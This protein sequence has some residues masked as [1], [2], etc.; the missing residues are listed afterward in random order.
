MK[1]TYLLYFI[2]QIPFIVY[3]YQVVGASI[4]NESL[5]N[6]MESGNVIE[7]GADINPIWKS[8]NFTDIRNVDNNKIQYE[9][10][11]MRYS[12]IGSFSFD[13][14]LENL[15]FNSNVFVLQIYVNFLNEAIFAEIFPNTEK[16]P[17]EIDKAPNGIPIN[18]KSINT[19]CV[20]SA[21]SIATNMALGAINKISSLNPPFKKCDEDSESAIYSINLFLTNRDTMDYNFKA[22]QAKFT[23]NQDI[24]G[25]SP[26]YSGNLLIN[27]DNENEKNSF[28]FSVNDMVTEC[29]SIKIL[30]E[31]SIDKYFNN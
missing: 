1:I 11:S 8:C 2:I 23:I 14:S 20:Y 31:F 4:T 13:K 7:Q 5:I 29:K 25:L 12:L 27:S 10:N 22:Q 18:I 24:S 16:I 6:S 3:N 19:D 26:K 15:K 28:D 9:L 17:N 30:K 21:P